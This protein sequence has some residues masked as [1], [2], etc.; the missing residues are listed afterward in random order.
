M[1][2]LATQCPS[3]GVEEQHYPPWY[4]PFQTGGTL[5]NAA[6]PVHTQLGQVVLEEALWRAVGSKWQQT[7]MQLLRDHILA[8]GRQPSVAASRP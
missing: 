6:L 8:V 3:D 2:P 5:I 7:W 1:D 4:F